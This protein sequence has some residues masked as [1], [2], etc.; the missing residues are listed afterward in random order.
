MSLVRV[1]KRVIRT[2]LWGWPVAQHNR[3]QR[4]IARLAQQCTDVLSLCISYLTCLD[5]FNSLAGRYRNEHTLKLTEMM[6]CII[7]ETPASCVLT[8]VLNTCL[9]PDIQSL[10][11]AF[12]QGIEAA[13][14]VPL[15]LCIL[16]WITLLDMPMPVKDPD[17]F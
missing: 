17:G 16:N 11:H 3:D 14:I 8:Q 15:R 7:E 4:I 12:R 1:N 10:G 2:S 9:Q 5:Q 6:P 13:A